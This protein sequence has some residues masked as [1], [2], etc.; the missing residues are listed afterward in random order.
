MVIN[1]VSGCKFFNGLVSSRFLFNKSRKLYFHFKTSTHFYPVFPFV[2]PENTRNLVFP[3]GIKWEHW[4]DMSWSNYF[5]I[6]HC[7]K[8]VRIRHYS[9]PRLFKFNNRD[10]V[11]SFLFVFSFFF[12]LKEAVYYRLH[13]NSI[14]KNSGFPYIKSFKVYNC[15]WLSLNFP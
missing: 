13:L 14:M 3:G 15:L 12:L 1:G 9:S 6:L 8:S 5:T 4:P 11:F 10:R 2:P 7:V